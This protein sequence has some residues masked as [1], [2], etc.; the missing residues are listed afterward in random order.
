MIHR[1]PIRDR[2]ICGV[3]RST[4]RESRARHTSS[5]A[6]PWARDPALTRDGPHARKREPSA[7]PAVQVPGKVGARQCCSS[8]ISTMCLAPIDR[9]RH[10]SYWV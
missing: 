5:E 2:M 10:A 4:Q 8:N 9:L 7:C 6:I 1:R 3:R